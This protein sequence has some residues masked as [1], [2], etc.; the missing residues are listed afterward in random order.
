MQALSTNKLILGTGTLSFTG[1]Q[2]SINTT[3]LTDFSKSTIFYNSAGITQGISYGFPIWR[4]NQACQVTGIH[5]LMMS[6]TV[7]TGF[8]NVRKNFT[9]NLLITNLR[10]NTTGAWISSGIIQN[11]NFVAGD[12]LEPRIISSSG[13]PLSISIQTDFITN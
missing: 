11:Q 4:A 6:G 2:L 7:P 9:S 13:T 10:V 12:T 8:I 1:N 5:V 3:S